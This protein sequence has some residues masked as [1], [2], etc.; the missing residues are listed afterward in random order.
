MI[1]HNNY[2]SQKASI[3]CDLGDKQ[4]RPVIDGV[5]NNF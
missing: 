5:I 2:I 4:K 3:G 1:L